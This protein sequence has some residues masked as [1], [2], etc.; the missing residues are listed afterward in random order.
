MDGIGAAVRT[1]ISRV[2]DATAK[3]SNVSIKMARGLNTSK[4]QDL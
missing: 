4:I 3:R 1:V 2:K